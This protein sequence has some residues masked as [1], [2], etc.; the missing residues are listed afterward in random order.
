MIVLL[1]WLKPYKLKYDEYWE[2]S[3]L[4]LAVACFFDPR[5]KQKLVQYFLL[6][7]YPDK[8]ADEIKRVMDA[9]HK[10]FQAYKCCLT[11]ESSKP[12]AVGPQSLGDTALGLGDIEE[13]L[14]EDAYAA[15]CGDKNELE[16]YMSEKPIR[17]VDPTGKG[18]R[19]DVLSWWKGNQ[20]VFPILSRL[21]RDVLAVQISTVGSESAFGA[22]GRV[23][24][25]FHSSLESEVIEALICTKDWERS[26]RKGHF[27]D[28]IETSLDELDLKLINKCGNEKNI[29]EEAHQNGIDLTRAEQE[30]VLLERECQQKGKHLEIDQNCVDTVGMESPSTTK[31]FTGGRSSD[32]VG[33]HAA[34]KQAYES[35]KN[36][37]TC[38]NETSVSN[39][40]QIFSMSS[41]SPSGHK[42]GYNVFPIQ[43]VAGGFAST[44]SPPSIPSR[45]IFS[46]DP[47]WSSTLISAENN[48]NQFLLQLPPPGSHGQPEELQLLDKF[49]NAL[50]SYPIL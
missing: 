10:L 18:E 24:S 37:V 44:S 8:A 36:V 38:N 13:F 35:W 25:P 19:F 40:L 5:F 20:M 43:V 29:N 39:L 32:Q 49:S 4:A 50:S 22:G 42:N 6:K 45:H 14:Y 23:V 41:P 47:L 48:K 30:Q 31:E 27:K 9:I 21:A 11:P 34:A 15:K 3:N 26:S 1:I 16:V 46:V 7:I 12:A 17:W 28:K 2:K 33:A